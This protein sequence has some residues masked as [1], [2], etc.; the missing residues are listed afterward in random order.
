MK[1][2]RIVLWIMVAVLAFGVLYLRFAQQSPDAQSIASA[3]LGG[4]FD[5][6]THRGEPITHERFS[7]RNHVLFF[8]FTHCPE[9]CPTTLFDASSWLKSLG[10]KAKDVDF[11]FITVDPERDTQEAL[12]YYVDAF[13]KRIVGI[14]GDP[15]EIE[16]LA[17]SYHIYVSRVE[18]EDGDYTVD[19]TASVLLFN[20]EGDFK[21]TIAFNENEETA[22]TKLRN[23][24][25][26]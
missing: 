16:N 11:Y 12:F 13:D 3:K 5:L 10:D 1:Q 9:I 17:S 14:T 4:P 6:I 26:K 2:V 19:H 20:E 8:G 15:K 18:L 22:L 21:G 23:L 25:Q 24:I 7:G